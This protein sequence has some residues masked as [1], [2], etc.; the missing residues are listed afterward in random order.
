MHAARGGGYMAMI[1]M[2]VALIV[3]NFAGHLP[4]IAE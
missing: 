2:A 1:R 4:E 3:D